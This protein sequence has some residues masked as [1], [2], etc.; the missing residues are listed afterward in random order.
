MASRDSSVIGGHEALQILQGLI[1]LVVVVVNHAH[2][3]HRLPRV[4]GAWAL[5]DEAVEIGNGRA[6]VAMHEVGIANLKQ[7]LVV[8]RRA[9]IGLNHVVEHRNL[10]I[11]IA[12]RAIT[13]SLLVKGIIGVAFPDAS[14][15]VVIVD[16]L[17]VTAFHKEAIA[18]ADVSIGLEVVL[19]VAGQADETPKTL[20]GSIIIGFLIVNVA[21]IVV[22]EAVFGQAGCRVHFLELG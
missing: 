2:L 7:G 18:E 19:A 10:L 9:R 11:H 17:V 16:G 12:F 21:Q 5:F 6:F 20:N 13:K 8:I 22:G 15:N 4:S 14:G 1:V 3:H